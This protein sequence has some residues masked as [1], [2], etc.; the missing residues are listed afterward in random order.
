MS[1]IAEQ[2]GPNQLWVPGMHLDEEY[3]VPTSEELAAA[4]SNYN[5]DTPARALTGVY[6][7]YT[8]PTQAVTAIASVDLCEVLRQSAVAMDIASGVSIGS[9]SSYHEN[10]WYDPKFVGEEYKMALVTSTL[11]VVMSEGLVEPV[12]HGTAIAAFLRNWRRQGIYCVANTSTLPGCERGTIKNTLERDY[13]GCFDALVLPRNY[14]GRGSVTKASAL[15]LLASEA[16]I[17]T[18]DMPMVHIDDTPHHV[19][20]FIEHHGPDARLQMFIPRHND[21]H[22]APIEM[23]CDTPLEAFIRADQY[24][25]NEGVT[26]AR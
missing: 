14:D 13:K 11:Q 20:S 12:E 22:H 23:Q 26:H 9:R 10:T 7:V 6:G 19:N 17:N 15:A 3:P 21:N 8:P 24:F 2:C 18:T 1:N 25:A 5:T 4:W 16:A